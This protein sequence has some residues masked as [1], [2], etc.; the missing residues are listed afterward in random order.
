MPLY[1]V[2]LKNDHVVYFGGVF[3]AKSDKK[4]W[5]KAIK[6][7]QKEINNRNTCYGSTTDFVPGKYEIELVSIVK[8][9]TREFKRVKSEK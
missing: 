1:R 8:I 3:G 2:S 5:K 7:Y 9:K 4:A 6:M